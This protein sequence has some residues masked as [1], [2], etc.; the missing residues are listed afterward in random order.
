MKIKLTTPSPKR[1]RQLF[2]IMRTSIF[3]FLCTTIFSFSPSNVFSQ[4]TTVSIDA[5]KVMTID[6]LFDLIRKQT[7]YRFIYKKEL[8]NNS[9][10]VHLKKGIIKANKLLRESLSTKDFSFEV[11]EN[12]IIVITAAP[13]NPIK[14]TGKVTDETGISLTG[15]TVR[16]AGTN[17]GVATDFEGNYEIT[18][19]SSETVLVFTSIGFTP[20]EITVG[21]QT[22]IN[23]SLKEAVNELDEVVINAGYYKTSKRLA[24]GNISGISSKTIEQQPVTNP[25]ATLQG[26]LAGVNITQAGG[27]PGSGFDIQI[28]GRNSIRP[29]GNA[30]LYIIDGLPFSSETLGG[31]NDISANILPFSADGG[32][33]TNPLNSIN[34]SDIESIEILKDADATAIYG[35]RGA[36]GVV[37]ITT[38]RG[39]PGKSQLGVNIY[40]GLSTVT[41]TMDLL[42]TEQY[43]E[44]RFEAFDNDSRPIGT[45]D[46]D[47]NGTWDQNRNTDWQQELIGGTAYTTDIQTSFSGGSANTQFLLS[48]GY[49]K[50]TTVFPGDFDYKKASGH[51]RLNHRSTNNKFKLSLSTSYVSDRNN[52]LATD[53]S[54]LAGILVPNA[55]ALH[56]EDGN[57]NWE[58]S[59]WQNPLALLEEQYLANTN[60]LI[61]NTVLDYEL[62]SGLS[63]KTNLGFNSISLIESKSSPSTRFNPAAGLGSERSVFTLNNSS[64]Q[65][66]II[67]PQIDWNIKL[68]KAKF[69]A[70]TGATFQERTSDRSV[71]RGTGF[72][73][74]S[75][76]TNISAASSVEVRSSGNIKYNYNGFFGRINYNWDDKYIL[77]LTGRRDGSS[78]FGPG[79][80][81]ANFWAIG[82]AWIFSEENI[83]KDNK[84]LSFGKLR[85]GYGTTGSDQIGDYQFLDTYSLT[86]D[87]DGQTGL[88]PTQ[89]FNQDF[90][91][92]IN[93]KLE[94][95]LELGFFK[96][97]ILLNANYYRNRSSNQLVGLPLS[98]LTGFGSVQANLD[99]T[100]QN[101]GFE[102][103]LN[104]IN[105]KKG[106]FTWRTNVNI[107]IPKNELLTF[108]ELEQSVAYGNTLVVGEPLNIKKVYQS[109]GVDPDT[110][111]YTFKDFNDDGLINQDDRQLI[112]SLD[113]EYYGGLSN[114]FSYK[115]L[116]LDFLF[117]FVKQTAGNYLNGTSVFPGISSNIPRNLLQDVWH[118]PG[119]EASIQR[120]TT[121]LNFPVLL[122]FFN[123]RNS[124]AAYSDASFVR[125]KNVSLSYQLSEKW[126]KGFN[127]RIYIQGQNLLTFTDYFG[128]DPENQSLSSLP[129]LKT[130]SLG[131][132]LTF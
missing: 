74:N 86:N 57:L 10:K 103:E 20:Q 98:A 80:Q 131:V 42:N 36:N 9:P 68:G 34:P 124:D 105:F 85:G 59:T 4:K 52:L 129:P 116:E 62:V 21:D 54:K 100:V 24:T 128:L 37:L 18:V 88:S 87:Y 11:K 123:Y 120:L 127:G 51:L 91:W 23:I 84:F 16:I 122:G 104:T 126:V 94:V 27:V 82:A 30:P 99:A 66:W 69:I 102:L 108:P 121:G 43:L 19:P 60:N 76:I 25:I 96:N 70:S 38:K 26:R 78:R 8:F 29:E 90:S 93:K 22:I 71:V 118:E 50:E 95:G 40:T 112:R 5:D 49:H 53:L 7:D 48:G 3:L 31:G 61:V 33:T 81:F 15:V 130:I 56:D 28:R 39:K 107:S 41:R 110:G 92:E 109:T 113:P 17:T 125:L 1:K 67:E 106:D 73:D 83:F 79:K 119:D 46:Y 44:M 63:L 77:N 12:K 14:V 32:R 101:S 89:L 55:P 58:N 132:Q 64:R 72:P 6:E 45:R 117:Q 47:V 35:S 97:G 111:V 75:L 13:Q 115:R 114:S 2:F 65:S